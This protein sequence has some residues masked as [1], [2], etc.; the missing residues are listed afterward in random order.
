[1]LRKAVQEHELHHPDPKTDDKHVCVLNLKD[2]HFI[3]AICHPNVEFSEDL[4]STEQ[5]C[6]A[7]STISSKATTTAEQIIGTFTWQMLKTLNTCPL[8]EA[9]ERQQLNQ[10]NNLCMYGDQIPQPADTVVLQQ[11]WQYH[12]KLDGTRHARNCRYGSPRATPSLHKY[13]QTYSPCVKQPV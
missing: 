13:A 6:I 9:G 2:I 8:R 4:I 11:H 12:I 7:A 1:V 5:A 10:L 3:S